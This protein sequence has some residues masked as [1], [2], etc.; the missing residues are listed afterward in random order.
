MFKKVLIANRGA[1]A[2]RIVRALH[3]INVEAVVVYSEA[4]VS[5]P[6][7]AAADQAIAIGPAA[8]KESYL[9][10]DALIAAIKESG[11]D[12]VHPGYGFFSENPDFADAVEAAGAKFIGPSTRWLKAMG[13][14]TE[15]RELMAKHGMTVGAGSDLLTEEAAMIAAANEIGYPVLIKPAAGGGGIGMLPAHDQEQLIKAAGRA[16]SMAERGFGNSDIYIE[17]L[18]EKPR[19]VEFQVLGDVHGDVCH[20]FERDCSIQRRHQKIIEEAPAPNVA[21]QVILEKADEITSTLKSLPYDNI[22][23]VEMLMGQDGSFSFLEMNTRL[24]VE[25][26]VSEEISGVDLVAAQVRSAAGESVGDI[27]PADVAVSG[28]AIQ[29]RVYAEDPIKFFPSPGPLNKFCLPECEGIRVETGFAEGMAVTPYYDPMVAKV[30]SKG[31]NRDDAI[32]KLI[33]ALEKF[34]IEGIKSNIP[35]LVQ[36]LRSDGF[37]S[38]DVHTGLTAEIIQK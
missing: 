11:A 32:E 30:L 6:Y 29:A 26:G 2:S 13:H 35:A 14:K 21:R 18:V 4:D 38:G 10:M 22:G 27:I 34:E 5:S 16:R 33:G 24:Q 37:R 28:H 19:H 1:I 17:R 8:P 20:V 9:N 23:T 12:G 3:N 15:A 36:I 31:K 25:H 7:V